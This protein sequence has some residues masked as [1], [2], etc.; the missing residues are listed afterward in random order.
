LP[1]RLIVIIHCL[2]FITLFRLF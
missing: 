1:L 2:D